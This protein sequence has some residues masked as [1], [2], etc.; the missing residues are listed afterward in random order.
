MMR[1]RMLMAMIAVVG[2]SAQLGC[3]RREGERSTGARDQRGEPAAPASEATDQT[4][5]TKAAQANLA[6]IEAGRLAAERGT[7]ADVKMFG[8]HMVDDHTQANRDLTDFARRKGYTIP[9][10][11]DDAHRKEVARLKE[12]SGADFDKRYVGMMVTDHEKAVALFEEHARSA[13][14]ADL[15]SFAEKGAP[16]LRDHLRMARDLQGKVGPPTAD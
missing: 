1:M 14:D 7:S 11:T 5:V 12:L 6:E 15:R 8:Q 13:K 2:L 16:K 9:E 3:D 4:F 10:Q